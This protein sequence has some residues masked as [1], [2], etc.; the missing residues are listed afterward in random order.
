ML[1]VALINMPFTEVRYPSI[2]L[3]Q[4]KSVV[5]QRFGS[6]VDTSIHYVN[7]EFAAELGA[8][9]FMSLLNDA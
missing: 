7:H 3:T 2:A 8:G 5:S 6:E 1:K 9:L 4:L